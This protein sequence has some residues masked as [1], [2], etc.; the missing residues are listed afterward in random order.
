[1]HKFKV[2]DKVRV[3]G[4][5]R[6]H[7]YLP[8]GSIVEIRDF[9]FDMVKVYGLCYDSN[10]FRM[11]DVYLENIESTREYKGTLVETKVLI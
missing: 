9:V 7:H 1:M 11:Q 3:T 5:S 10:D 4:T 6:I 2:G 8:V